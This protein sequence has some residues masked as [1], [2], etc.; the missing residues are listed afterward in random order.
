[1]AKV[2][3][4]PGMF[5]AHS[6]TEVYGPG[7]VLGV[8]GELRRV[9]FIHFVATIAVRSLRAASPDEEETVREWLKQKEMRYGGTW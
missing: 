2:L 7:K 5:V 1:M 6:E 3:H 9:R 4:G 8:D